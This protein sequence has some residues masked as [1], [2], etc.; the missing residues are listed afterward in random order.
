MLEEEGF[1]YDRY[2]DVFDGGPTVTAPT[3]NIRT[4]RESAIERIA[5]IG[6][7]NGRT[8]MLLAAGRLNDFRA[9]CASVKRLR[10][11]G[12]CIDREC[13]Q[14]LEVEVGDEVL[15]VTR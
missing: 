15:A 3:D 8:K 11:S 10:D 13:A 12:L 7:N 14:L 2:L 9:C 6:E 5:E 4:V 1:S